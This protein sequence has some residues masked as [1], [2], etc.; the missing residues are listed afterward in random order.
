MA[1]MVVNHVHEEHP[2]FAENPDWFNDGCIC[3]STG[4]DWTE[5]RLDCLFMSYMPDVDWR[6]R[7]ASEQFIADASWWVERFD[8]DGL[9]IDAVKHV[10]DNAVNNMAAILSERFEQ[11]GVELYLKGETAMGWSGD[12]IEDWL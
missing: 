4:C 12:S 11:A 7:N 2:Y 5:R 8:L 10:D 9:R 1:D 3:G 6:N